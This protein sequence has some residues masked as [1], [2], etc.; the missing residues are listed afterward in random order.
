MKKFI[1]P[2]FVFLLYFCNYNP[3]IDNEV[4]FGQVKM[5]I[6]MNLAPEDVT[7]LAGILTREG[8]DSVF[9]NFEIIDNNAQ[10][11]IENLEQGQWELYVKA[12]NNNGVILYDGSVTVEIIANMVSTVNLHLDPLSTTG[13]IQIKITWGDLPGKQKIL[14]M[15][16]NN[17][18]MWR[19]LSINLDGSGFQDI[20]AG[21][22]PFWIDNKDKI[23]FRSSINSLLS[24]NPN[25]GET[26]QEHFIP[27]HGNFFR[28]STQYNSIVFDYMIEDHNWNIGYYSLSNQE[29]AHVVTDS[30]W[31]KRPVPLNNSDWIYY[32]SDIT[33]TQHI[34]KVNYGGTQI[35]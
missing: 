12:M 26:E 32:Q 28:Y 21:S 25:T 14:F 35:I 8:F 2:I 3:L 6:D 27:L 16:Q 5:S 19:V 20:I 29:I 24:Y 33:G 13:S 23:Y 7:G 4:S 17:A 15:A 10:A 30:S 31:N 9:F 11:L 22:Y 1:L 34:Y 18:N